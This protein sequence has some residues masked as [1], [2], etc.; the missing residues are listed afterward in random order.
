V[1]D[2]DGAGGTIPDLAP[3]L[4]ALRAGLVVGMPTDTVYGLAADPYRAEA[5]KALFRLKGRPEGNPVPVLAADADQ[6]RTVAVFDEVALRAAAD[7][8]P[9]PLTL[10]LPRAAGLPPWVGSESEGSVGVRVPD[11]RAARALL[12]AAGPLAVTSA[13]RSGGDPVPDDAGARAIFGNEVAAYLAGGSG[14]GL[15]STVVDLTPPTDPAR[16]GGPRVLRR[17]PVAWEES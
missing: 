2:R 1:S 6:A 14:G 8:W 13:N 12:A 10:V 7:H 15:P 11:H 17:G 3:V 9:G 16:P 5:M 4:A